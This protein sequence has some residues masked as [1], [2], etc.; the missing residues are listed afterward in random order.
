MKRKG[1]NIGITPDFTFTGLA[2]IQSSGAA[3]AK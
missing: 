2:D 3:G 1:Y